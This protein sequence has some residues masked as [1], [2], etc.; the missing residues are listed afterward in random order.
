MYVTV[1]K[2]TQYRFARNA[3]YQDRMRKISDDSLKLFG[4]YKEIMMASAIIGFKNGI[5]KE[6]ENIA[7][8]RVQ[9]IN[10]TP[11]DL[12]IIDL[13]AYA[14]TK[15]QSILNKKEKYAIFENYANGGFP[16]LYEKLGIDDD[17]TIDK[18]EELLNKYYT[19]LMDPKGFE[20]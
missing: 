14:H 15:E 12:E 11:R 8:D 17:T 7:S 3:E 18:R 19:I 13:I 16:I 10:F 5:Y 1:E 4:G 9:L 2:G 20:L 6:I